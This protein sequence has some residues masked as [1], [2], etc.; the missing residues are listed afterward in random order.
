MATAAGAT[1][2]GKPSK[3]GD[4]EAALLARGL[5]LRGRRRVNV[6]TL[7]KRIEAM[8]AAAAF[9]EEGEADTARQIVAEA[10]GKDRRPVSVRPALPTRPTARP[11]HIHRQRKVAR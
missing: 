9:A 4:L 5:L 1:A 7:L 6:R 2:V 11:R 3:T 10:E 8:F